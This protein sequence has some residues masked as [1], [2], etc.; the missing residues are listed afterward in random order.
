MGATLKQLAVG[1]ANPGLFKELNLQFWDPTASLDSRITFTRTGNASR[2]NHL[3]VLETVSSGVARAHEYADHDPATLGTS[4]SSVAIGYGTKTFADTV[5]RSVGSVCRATYDASNYLIG[6]VTASNGSSTTMTVMRSAGS[7]TYASWTLIEVLGFLIE[8]QR[9]NSIKNNTMVGASAPSTLPTNWATQG[10]LSGLTR[11]V[12]GTGTQYGVEYIDIRWYGTTSGSGGTGVYCEANNGIAA[13]NGQ[14][15]SD[16]V[17]LAV[18]G[19]STAG[20]T[21]LRL[22]MVSRDSMGASLQ[23]QSNDVL[24]SVGASL[25][26][27][28][29]PAFTLAHASTAY[30][31]SGPV[32][33]FGAGATIDITLRIGLPQL[34]L[35]AFATSPIPTSGSAATRLADSA[36]M[37]GTAFS[38]WYRQE[39]G[40]FVAS[41]KC[42]GLGGSNT[43][44]FVA[45]VASSDFLSFI[46]IARY[47]SSLKVIVNAPSQQANMDT[48]LAIGTQ[49]TT[50]VAY[51]ADS[52]ALS[53][54]GAT[55]LT[56]TSGSLPTPT[57]LYIGD[58]GAPSSRSLNGTIRELLY[59]RQRVP[60][61]QLQTLSEAA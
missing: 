10:G 45:Q 43:V 37:T 8:E 27:F 33:G 30:I 5:T 28:L 4:A 57:G 11:E 31:H 23:G 42:R 58:D 44:S 36:T 51:K 7:G 14:T 25:S 56:D 18:V 39:E 34:E 61:A 26:R 47:Q 60:N 46:D 17:F 59:F 12:V 52:F 29:N 15:W 35:G 22:N 2:W 1:T 21:Y 9:L 50:A 48:A 54:D 13:S 38:S 41:A 19:G 20:V 24:S 55:P 32:F 53:V 6:R 49:R 3:G 16:S 40:T